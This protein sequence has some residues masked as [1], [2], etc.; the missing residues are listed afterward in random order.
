MAQYWVDDVSG[1]PIGGPFD[2]WRPN[3]FRANGEPPE[4]TS[5]MYPGLS[6]STVSE[7]A[8]ATVNDEDTLDDVLSD[9]GKR[10]PVE[11]LVMAHAYFS[12]WRKRA[13]FMP[14]SMQGI[15]LRPARTS[16][17]PLEESVGDWNVGLAPALKKFAKLFKR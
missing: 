5:K 10:G 16:A 15:P 14:D 1:C 13:P 17:E 11:Q 3:Y 9:F 2:P 7:V 6:A 8:I 4:D 12:E